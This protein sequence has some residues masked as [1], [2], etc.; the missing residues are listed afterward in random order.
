MTILKYTEA[1]LALLPR[2]ILWDYARE[3]GSVWYLLLDACGLE[4]QRIEDRALDLLEEADPRTADELLDEWEVV[5]GLPEEWYT[6]TTDDERRNQLFL[7][8]STRGSQKE[9]YYIE[10]AALVG[11]GYL[12]YVDSRPYYPFVAGSLCGASIY[13]TEWVYVWRVYAVE[14]TTQND[15]HLMGLFRYMKRS[16]SAI[17]FYWIDLT[18]WTAR[19]AGGGSTSTFYAG[20]H[21]REGEWN[22]A[23]VITGGGG[24]IQLSVDGVTWAVMTAAGGYTGVFSGAAATSAGYVIVGAA[25]EIQTSAD[26]FTWA[27]ISPAGGYS[28]DFSDVEISSD[29]GLLC[30]VGETGEIQTSADDGATWTAQTP[31]G[32]Y[33]YTFLGVA[34]GNGTWV[35]VGL[36]GEVQTSSDGITWTSVTVTSDSFVDITWNGTVFCAITSTYIAWVSSD[37]AAWTAYS[38]PSSVVKSVASHASGVVVACFSYSAGIIISKDHGKTWT[39]QAVNTPYPRGI[40]WGKSQCIV[41]GG[42]GRIETSALTEDISA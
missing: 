14:D 23:Y 5:A 37:G 2:G 7:K 13:G 34:Y 3:S 24:T 21:G 33:S 1:L 26:G 4:F 20:A 18:T 12:I 28:D 35:V 11:D 36:Y 40:V 29:D 15:N 6:P 16:H 41:I 25:G 8:I 27:A 31:A 9:S 10:Q 42:S 17:E 22:E 30:A 38:L 39:T 19:T 32:G